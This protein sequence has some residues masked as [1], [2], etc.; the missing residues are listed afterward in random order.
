MAETIVIR[1]SNRT[2]LALQQGETVP[3]RLHRKNVVGGVTRRTGRRSGRKARAKLW[4]QAG[5]LPAPGSLPARLLLWAIAHGGKVTTKQ[6]QGVFRRSLSHA[7]GMLSHLAAAGLLRRDG[8]ARYVVTAKGRASRK[9]LSRV[10]PYR[11][12]SH[13]AR[14]L[15]WARKR[16]RAF[17]I[18][19]VARL[20]GV[21]HSSVHVVLQRLLKDRF[22][23]RERIGAYRAR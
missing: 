17:G 7:S 23:V 18:E 5:D 13:R 20:L 3:I 12:G 10:S 21:G 6:A 15:A 11:E 19:D 22:V 16:R 8:W 2:L 9:A 4:W 1:V 14:V